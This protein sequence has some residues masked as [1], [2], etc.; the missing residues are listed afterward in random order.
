M[1]AKTVLVFFGLSFGVF[2]L[3]ALIAPESLARMVHFS[4][5]TPGAV[6]EIRAFYGGLEL[7]LAILMLAAAVYPALVPGAL[8]TLVAA[9]GGI[10]LARIV[11]LVLDG[12]GS[13]FMFGALAWEV[14][15]AV[16]GFIAYSRLDPA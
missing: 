1:F 3:W 11:G 6:T 15:G 2:G 4:L 12:S 16:L 8:L 9:A 10:A 7:G 5:D 13:A 14:A